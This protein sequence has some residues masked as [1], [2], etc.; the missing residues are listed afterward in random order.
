MSDLKCALGTTGFVWKLNKKKMVQ[1]RPARQ[2][3]RAALRSAN[4]RALLL[5][6]FEVA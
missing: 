5:S 6:L 2:V 3:V 1:G 4:L